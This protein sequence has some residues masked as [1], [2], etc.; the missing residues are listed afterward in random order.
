MGNKGDNMGQIALNMGYSKD[1]IDSWTPK[2]WQGFMDHR[3][4]SFY[5]R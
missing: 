2:Q 5:G 4:P 3:D 1:Q